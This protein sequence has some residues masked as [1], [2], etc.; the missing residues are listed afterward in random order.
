MNHDQCSKYPL[1]AFVHAFSYSMQFNMDLLNCF[2]DKS[3]KSQLHC[4]FQNYVC[5]P[6]WLQF[7]LFLHDNTPDMVSVLEKINLS[8]IVLVYRTK[9]ATCTLPQFV[10]KFLTNRGSV[11]VA[12]FVHCL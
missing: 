4:D 5:L 2:Y 6:L 10:K 7:S 3:F 12:S 9:L 11:H 8:V 1:F